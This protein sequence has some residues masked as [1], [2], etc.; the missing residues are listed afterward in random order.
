LSETGEKIG[1]IRAG[2]VRD[3]SDKV[4]G[5]F[6]KEKGLLTSRRAIKKAIKKEWKPV[7][8]TYCS[9]KI[10][11]DNVKLGKP[12][13]GSILGDNIE[14][15][16]SI[17]LPQYAQSH[18]MFPKAIE[19]EYGEKI[20]TI[21]EKHSIDI[22]DCANGIPL[23]SDPFLGEVLGLPVHSGPVD[24]LHGPKFLEYVYKKLSKKDTEKN[25]LKVLNGVKKSICHNKMPWLK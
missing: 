16:Y 2:V 5:Y 13:S 3:N 7:M 10:K 6:S 20:R 18:H 17:K 25:V 23:P 15:C 1:T 22:N 8:D 9:S 19:G 4:I 12:G 24:T 21:L 11:G 14:A